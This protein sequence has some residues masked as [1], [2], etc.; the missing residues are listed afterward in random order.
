MRGRVK[1]EGHWDV[2]F[3]IIRMEWLFLYLRVSLIL[4][5]G[6]NVVVVR[7]QSVPRSRRAEESGKGGMTRDSDKGDVTH[8]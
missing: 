6:S 1:W 7:N 3:I 5:T 4:R 8:P 2:L